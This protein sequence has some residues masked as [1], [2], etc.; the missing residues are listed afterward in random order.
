MFTA[1]DA[2]NDPHPAGEAPLR[3]LAPIRSVPS[4]RGLRTVGL[5][6]ISSSSRACR[7][8]APEIVAKNNVFRFVTIVKPLRTRWVYEWEGWSETRNESVVPQ[9]DSPFPSHIPTASWD[10]FIP[11]HLGGEV[12]SL[13][14][15][16]MNHPKSE[17]TPHHKLSSPRVP[18]LPHSQFRDDLRREPHRPTVVWSINK[19]L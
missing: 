7:S 12:H 8:S 6:Y 9:I 2:E 14:G 10:G 15:A 5:Q 16:I 19:R 18:C 11:I 1:G 17:R 3:S 13:N 4:G